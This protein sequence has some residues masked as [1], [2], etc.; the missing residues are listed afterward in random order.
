[1]LFHRRCFVIAELIS[2]VWLLAASFR[3]GFAAA[4]GDT[5]RVLSSLVP[6]HQLELYHKPYS[7]ISDRQQW[8]MRIH[9]LR[10]AMLHPLV[11]G[12]RKSERTENRRIIPL[13]AFILRSSEDPAYS[14]RSVEIEF[15][16]E[17]IPPDGLLA[18]PRDYDPLLEVGFHGE[19]RRGEPG[20]LPLLDRGYVIRLS[21]IPGLESGVFYRSMSTYEKLLAA[22]TPPVAGGR[23][24]LIRLETDG[25][26]CRLSIDG[27]QVLEYAGEGLDR[28]FVSLRSGWHPLGISRLEVRGTK[29]SAEKSHDVIESGLVPAFPEAFRKVE[30]ALKTLPVS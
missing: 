5:P 27:K 22:D 20:A 23:K 15:E 30:P 24:Y 14:L 7:E 9:G 21:G 10:H 19:F 12:T 1:M 4:E 13:K 29:V 18:H 2:F 28:G 11:W 25:A 6:P 26:G 3:P 16:F 8:R 17:R